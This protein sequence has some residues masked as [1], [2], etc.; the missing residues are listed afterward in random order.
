MKNSRILFHLAITGGFAVLAAAGI[1]Y[2]FL[3]GEYDPLALGL[4]RTVQAAGLAGLL[5]VPTGAVWLVYELQ[6]LAN[7]RNDPA[8]QTAKGYYFAAAAAVSTLLVMVVISIAAVI[9]AGFVFGLL[10]FALCAFLISRAITG[11]KQMRTDD[12]WEFNAVPVYMILLPVFAVLLQ[13][14]AAASMTD[15]SRSRAI[16][17]SAELI[18]DLE[19]FYDAY[20]RYPRSLHAVWKDYSPGVIGVDQ[21]HYAAGEEGYNLFFEQP[22]FLLDE[23]GVREFVVYNPENQQMMI[24]HDAWILNVPP[25]EL[26]RAQGWYAVHDST[27]PHWKYFWFD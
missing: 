2:P 10:I 25:E 3:P 22:R 1:L 12:A 4:S 13:L 8:K 23:L 24:S 6:M 15:F 26:D 18:R 17:N 20:G 5:F 16:A 21:Y 19:A 11:L 7:G 9:S 27:W 14:T